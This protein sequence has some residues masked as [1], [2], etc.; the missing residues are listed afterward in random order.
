[1]HSLK[2]KIRKQVLAAR[3]RLSPDERRSKS[4]EIERRLFGLPEFRT[5]APV[6]FFA[7]FQSEVET[8]FMVRR[9]L[10]EGRRVALPKVQGRSLALLEIRNFDAEVSP[11]AWGIPEPDLGEPV[12]PADLGLIIVPGAVFDEQG[13]RIGYGAGFYDRLLAS[14][15]GPTV[16][17]AFELQVV[18]AVPAEPHDVPVQKI[19]TE[20]R[21]IEV[22]PRPQTPKHK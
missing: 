19:V 8:H 4:G 6:L 10:A 16:A 20:K 1:M 21:I 5:K 2:D 3:S 13:N 7:S 22:N 17:L 15:G 11:G 14:Y 9:A 18:P 12:G